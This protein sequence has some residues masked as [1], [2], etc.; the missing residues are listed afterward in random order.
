VAQKH[1]AAI[2]KG[3]RILGY[4]TAP[5]ESVHCGLRAARAP[6]QNPE[7]KDRNPV[8]DVALVKKLKRTVPQTELRKNPKL[9]RMKLLQFFR[10]IAVSPLT[11]AEYKEILRLDSR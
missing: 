2:K 5:E 1:I 7:L 4:H 8:L 11:A 10:P 9:R 3:D 6:H